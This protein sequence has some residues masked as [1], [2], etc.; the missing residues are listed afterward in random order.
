MEHAILIAGCLLAIL[1]HSVAWFGG[2][3]QFL[4]DSWKNNPLYAVILFGIPSNIIFWQASKFLF[5]ETHS[6]WQ[7]RWIMFAAS[8]PAMYILSKI[9]FDEPFFTQ[10]NIITMILAVCIICVQFYYRGK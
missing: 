6:I 3:S 7:I 1:G 5:Q 9:F 4:W 10:K 8:F 2:N